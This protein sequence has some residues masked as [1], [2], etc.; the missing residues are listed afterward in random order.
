MRLPYTLAVPILS[1][2]LFAT[3]CATAPA[4]LAPQTPG[5][6]GASL[7]G[8]FG[9]YSR[10][11][12]TTSRAAQRWFDQGMQLLYGFN[13]DEA[14]RA[15]LEAAANDPG[16]A[17]AY[18]GIAYA[19]GMNIND[20][21]MTEQRS[22]DAYSAMTRAM[23]LIDTVT[24]AERALIESVHARYAWPPPRDRRRLDEAYAESLGSAW[25][26][27]PNDPDI[28]ALYAESLM[29]LQPWDYWT[30]DG[31]PKGRIEEVVDTLE[32]VIA[33]RPDHAGANHFYIHAVEAS[34]DPD[35]AVP[36]A[37]R[38]AHLVPASG[39]LVHMPSHVFIRVGRYDDAA[40]ANEAAIDADRA[41][42]EAANKEQ[43][44]YQLYYAHNLHFL[45][46]ASMMEG[47]YET[48]IRAAN[49]LES[50][51]PEEFIRQMPELVEG[52]MSTSLHVMIRFGRWEEI[53]EV[54]EPAEFRLLSR[55]VRLYARG[56]ALSALGRTG[57]A[58]IEMAAFEEAIA[59]VPVDW[60]VFN[61]H[62]HDV[63]PIARAMLEGELAYR[64]GRTSEAF[65]ILRRGV[66]AEDALVY[67]EPP[68]WMLPVRHALGA[69]LMG[70][71]RYGEAERVYREDLRR[72]RENGW[73]L[74]GLQ[75]A[76]KAQGRTA[77]ADALN[78]RI[79][80]AWP[81][82][83][84]SPTSSCYCQPATD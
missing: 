26:R 82:K 84:V 25:A 40:L 27:F 66:A 31:E 62:V 36:A 9:D 56:I 30:S 53:L 59:R 71:N 17:M 35:C 51:I 77:E 45:A 81:R 14:V 72:N 47:R 6:T 46:F 68:G 49:E 38:L 43:G 78:M 42:F 75:N 39:H 5:A 41:Y 23:E 18:W 80:A 63:L 57:E 55:A 69:L 54:P 19:N 21:D 48:A 8:G 13:H 65:E 34:Q 61:N 29:D 67:D 33:M 83:D 15:F 24:P 60:W 32:R 16:C 3:G 70:D 44:F 37:E 10:R 28:G 12:T 64:E 52:I 2:F 79:A 58:R 76:L 22:R 4:P 7:Y 74:L 20:P 50:Q 1:A 11:V 73:A